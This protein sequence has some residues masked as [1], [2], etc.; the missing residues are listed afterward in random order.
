MDVYDAIPYDRLAVAETHPD[1][2]A[3]LGRL[4]GMRSADPRACSVLELGCAAGAN[5]VPMAWYLAQSRFLGIDLSAAQVSAGQQLIG[6]LGLANI[7]IR[8]GDVAQLD[9]G[10]AQFD[11]VIAHGLYSW[12]PGSVRDALLQLIRRALAAGGIAYVSFNALPGWRMRGMLRDMLLYRVR[13]VSDPVQRLG[14]AREFLGLLETGLH[15]LDGLSAEYLRHELAALRGAPD[16]YLYHEYLAAVNEP[17]L[18]ADFVAAARAAGLR[19]LCNATLYQQFPAAIGEGAETAAAGFDDPLERQQF[20]DFLLNRNFHQALLVRDDSAALGAPDPERFAGFALYA[21]L[22]AP[23]KLELRRVRPQPF[24]DALGQQHLVRHPLTKAALTRLQQVYPE[25]LALA[26]IEALA[27]RQVAAAGGRGLA[28]Q[29]D[30][31]FGELFQLFA[32]GALAATCQ[33]GGASVAPGERPRSTALA[34]AE[35]GWGRLVDSRHASLA[36]DPLVAD[37]VPALDGSLAADGVAAW[38]RARGAASLRP[39][40]VLRELSR[41]GAL[42]D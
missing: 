25:A 20:L 37:L 16:S 5:L 31:L 42:G 40:A 35:A 38:L 13:A 12:V 9:L 34:R 1:R 36:L 10:G 21:D 41:R 11:Y 15:G 7:E 2:L 17:L 14:R 29:T 22:R 26:E 28:E 24:V 4:H 32:H 30:H 23:H 8:Q 27:A 3:V 6:Q 39:D 18:F 33:P 19:Y